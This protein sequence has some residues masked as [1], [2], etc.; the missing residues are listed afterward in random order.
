V[1]VF[2]DILANAGGV[3]VSYFEWVQNRQRFYWSEQRV[4]DELETV[5][6]NAF[7]RLTSTY[8]DRDLPNFRTAA[9]V[10]AIER[11]LRASEQG[12][13]WP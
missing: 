2:P 6:V 5:I 13:V 11:V 4:N 12:G 7:D 10:V 1:S 8:E 3:T 9:Y